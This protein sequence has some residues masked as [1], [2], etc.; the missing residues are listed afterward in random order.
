MIA[1]RAG[2]AYGFCMAFDD[3]TSREEL[4]AARK[5]VSAQLDQIHC[6][7]GHSLTVSSDSA[8]RAQSQAELETILDEIDA[9]LAD[10]GPKRA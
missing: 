8:L 2:P 7:G 3:P 5:R 10:L 9:E 6:I 1:G 4:L